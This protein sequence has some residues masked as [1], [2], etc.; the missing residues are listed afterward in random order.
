MEQQNVAESGEAGNFTLVNSAD[1]SAWMHLEDWN[2]QL[3]IGLNSNSLQTTMNDPVSSSKSTNA[4]KS[5]AKLII[6]KQPEQ[7]HRARYL[8]EGSRGA[9]KDRSGSSHCT[10]QLTGYF[11]PTRV[12]IFAA[13]GAG[14]LEPHPLYK[15]I[16]VS[17]KTPITTPCKKIT[18]HDG[19]DCLEVTLRPE[20]QMTAVLDCMGILKICSYDVRQQQ[21]RQ[22]RTTSSKRQKP[23]DVTDES[24][25]TQASNLASTCTRICFRAYVLDDSKNNVTILKSFTEP[26][27]CV[28]QLGVPEVLK[29]SL[30]SAPSQ[31][32]MDLFIIGRNFDRNTSVLFREYTD[33]GT[34]GWSAEAAIDKAYF[35]QC[36]IVCKVPK[37][38]NVYRGGSVSI[39]VKCGTKS[40]H[41]T[42]FNYIACGQCKNQNQPLSSNSMSFLAYDLPSSRAPPASPRFEI[43]RQQSSNN[44]SWAPPT[45]I[46]SSFYNSF[47]DDT[48]VLTPPNATNSSSKF[49]SSYFD[50]DQT[51]VP[52][53]GFADQYADATP[54]NQRN[55][56]SNT[57]SKRQRLGF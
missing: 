7:Q 52:D 55:S 23:A 16:P 20:S 13:H 29:M 56:Q 19:I 10:I 41:P 51:F 36:H 53:Y 6:S 8:S 32:G 1:K 57:Q 9:I 12:E 38:P 28:Q 17:G 22:R 2:T 18:A 45:S 34:I 14:E 48:S 24:P 21:K 46:Q 15:L 50:Y 42:T 43:Q 54:T 30:T 5:N 31:G 39:T 37:Y 4:S 3:L 47:N 40:S 33:E 49:M 35:H 11:R 27:R 44:H 26:I 25:E